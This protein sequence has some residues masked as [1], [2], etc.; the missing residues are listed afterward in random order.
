MWPNRTTVQPTIWRG[1]HD[2]PR[3]LIEHHDANVGV[4]IGNLLA[5]E[6]Y[7]VSTCTGPSER[8]PCPVAD[9]TP[10]ARVEEADLVLFGLEVEDEIDRQVLA[11]LKASVPH[12]P[13]VVEIPPTRVALYQPELENCVAVARPV[14]RDT[15]LDAVE[16][17]LR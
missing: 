12:I 1:P 13:I 5:S 7:E 15:L 4:A 3:I 17:A 11:G 6:G 16:R 10:C 8:R 14:T 2:R 9:G